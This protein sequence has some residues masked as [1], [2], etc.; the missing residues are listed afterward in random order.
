[1][2]KKLTSSKIWL[3]LVLV[4]GA[5]LAG[6]ASKGGTPWRTRSK[7]DKL[8]EAEQEIARKR[9]EEAARNATEINRMVDGINK[10]KP[11]QSDPKTM[12]EIQSEYEKL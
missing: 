6:L 3:F 2:W 5:I 11:A 4:G 10:P 12:K 7:L 9:G 8:Q 1:M